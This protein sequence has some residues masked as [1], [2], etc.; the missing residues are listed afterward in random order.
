VFR[1]PS[2]T[3]GYFN[4]PLATSQ[5]L[6]RRLA[7]QRRS[8]LHRR[9]RVSSG[10]AQ[11]HHHR[12]GRNFYPQEMEEI[13]GEI[14]GVRKGASCVRQSDRLRVRAARCDRRNPRRIRLN[15]RSARGDPCA[16][17]EALGER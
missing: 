17:F 4:N 12:G 7:G 2:A 10:R 16:I 8:R 13:V 11:G 6:L 15:W 1:G 3:R 14:P 9:W 5:L